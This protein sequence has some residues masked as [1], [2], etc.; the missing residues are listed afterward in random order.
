MDGNV[1]IRVISVWKK[2]ERIGGPGA[3]TRRFRAVRLFDEHGMKEQQREDRVCLI[4][5]RCFGENVCGL[6][7]LESLWNRL[8]PAM[9]HCHLVIES[10]R[11][12][13]I[14][15]KIMALISL[16]EFV[17]EIVHHHMHMDVK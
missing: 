17:A 15:E 13:K 4:P 6:S 1:I 12:Q 11:G 16:F 2:V 7:A 9:I 10:V 8:E 5:I 3:V 14:R